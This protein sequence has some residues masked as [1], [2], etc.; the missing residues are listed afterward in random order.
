MAAIAASSLSYGIGG[1]QILW[2]PQGLL[3]QIVSTHS[4]YQT[5]HVDLQH[6]VNLISC[7]FQNAAVSSS[8]GVEQYAQL[9]D[10]INKLETVDGMHQALENI[11]NLSCEMSCCV[12]TMASS[13]DET[14]MQMLRRLKDY[15]WN[16]KVVLAMAAF[17][18]SV[19][20][21]SML[22]KHRNTDPIAMYVETLKGHRYTTTDFTV[23]ERIGLFKAMI[24]VANTNLAFLAPSISRIPKE[25]HSIKDA[26]ACFPTAAYKILRIVLQITSILSKKKDHFE[27]TIQELN[28]L[29]NEVS[30]INNILQEKLTLCLRDAE[31]YTYEDITIRITKISI[32]EFID[33]IMHYVRIQ[34]FENLRNKHLLFLVSDLDISIDEIKVLNWLYERNDQMYEIVWLP[35]ID[36]SMSYDVKR[37]WELKQLMKWSVAVEPTRVEA[38]VVEFVKKEWHFIR[39]AIAVSMTSAGE[40]VCQN[41]LPMLW[42]WGNTAFP[43]SDKTEQILWNSVDER[44]GWKL[45]LVLDDFIVPELRSWIE[46]RT[47]FVCLFGGG[48]ISWIQEFTEKVKYAAYAAGVTLKLV[49]VGKNKAKLGLSKTDLSRDIKVIESEI[50]WRFWTKLESILHAKI[51]HGK[52]TTAYKTDV[53]IH[54]ALKVVGHGGKGESWA[55]FSMG[56][57]P[58]VTTDGETGLTIMSNYLNWRQDTT[59]LRFLEG[60][61]HYKEVISRDVHG[62]IK[63]HLPVL[64]R[65]PGIMVCPDCSKVMDMFYTYRC[66]DE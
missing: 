11:R 10:I 52:T 4:S 19:G 35:I 31:K 7:I 13:V 57:D 50:R 44:H 64:G 22:V 8:K 6:L 33:K 18:C 3:E 56:P 15:S 28:V 30:H 34:G 42:T 45:D 40:V 47:T 14:M 62:C 12:S 61:K 26:I 1:T 55:V 9:T 59:G 32:S 46:N 36:L 58:M 66:C 49:F 24:D 16:A 5:H 27:S 51:R 48:D 21:S 23:L 17:A 38:D 60:V 29:A 65:V 53:V 39:Q 25:V 43:F 37:F 41:A 63:V 54:E 20:E 2:V